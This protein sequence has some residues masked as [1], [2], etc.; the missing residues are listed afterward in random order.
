MI[1]TF[2]NIKKLILEKGVNSTDEID[3]ANIYILMNI[4]G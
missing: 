1:T 3:L 4:F 2:V